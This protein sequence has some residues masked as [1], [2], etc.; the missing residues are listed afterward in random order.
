MSTGSPEGQLHPGLHKKLSGQQVEGVDSAPLLCPT[1]TPAGVL[2]PAL[3]SS[4]QERH[5]SAGAGPEEDH[6]DNQR[7]RAPL[8]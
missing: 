2:R 1:E 3:R 4:T 6:K 5:G 7:V 8:L